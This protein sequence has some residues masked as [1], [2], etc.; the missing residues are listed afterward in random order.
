VSTTILDVTDLVKTFELRSHEILVAVNGVSCNVQRGETLGIVG[1]SGSGKTTLGRC[2]LR[3]LEP[4]AGRIVF[5]D[6]E[7]TS[8]KSEALRQQ[9]AKMQILYQDPMATFNPRMR[10]AQIIAEPISL[11]ESLGTLDV[12]RRVRE[13]LDMVGLP[14]TVIAR[15]PDELNKGEQQLIAIARAIATNPKM[16]VLD[17]PTGLLDLSVRVRVIGILRSLQQDLDIAYIFISHDL[18]TVRAISHRLAI[19]YLGKVVETGPTEEL[20]QSPKHP[21]SL[22]LLSSVLLPRPERVHRRLRLRGEIP[23]PINL[24]PGCSLASR[25][26]L[27]EP[28]CTALAPPKVAISDPDDPE[29]WATCHPLAEASMSSWHERLE[30][31]KSTELPP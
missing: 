28:R 6:T 7:L 24:P 27:A 8:L 22:A 2:V 13:L 9:R 1:E 21:Y 4:D 12:E 26:P 3:L 18:S 31:A 23:S 19:M 10:V 29:W 25:C 11:H 5:D 30:L 15:R 20:F 16:I 14:E 17:E